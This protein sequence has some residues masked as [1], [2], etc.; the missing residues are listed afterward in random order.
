MVNKIESK[1][2]NL[3]FTKYCGVYLLYLNQKIVYV[4]VSCDIAVRLSQH[5]TARQ[6]YWDD[7]KIIEENDYL[8]A[9]EIENYFIDN[10]NPM[11]NKSSGKLYLEIMKWGDKFDKEKI[12]YP[13]GWTVKNEENE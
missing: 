2:I 1:I 3:P 4:G 7:V 9:I 6:K 13:S 12:K 8:K 5:W 11:Y 10:Y